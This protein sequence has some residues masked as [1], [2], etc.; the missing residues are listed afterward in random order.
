[1][2]DDAF[3]AWTALLNVVDPESIQTLIH[4]TFSIIKQNWY[5][6][7]TSTQT[8]A[9]EVVKGLIEKHNASIVAHVDMLPSLG[10]I[11]LLQK[12]ESEIQ[13]HKTRLELSVQLQAFAKRCK[14]ENATVVRQALQELE[15]F[16]DKC[17]TVLQESASGHNPMPI[18]G[19]LCRSL[20]DA[21]IRFKEN[22]GEIIDLCAKCLGIIG[23]ID[24]NRVET[25]REKHGILV[26]SNFDSLPEVVEFVAH[27]LE[28]VIV[29]AFRSAPTGKAQSYLAYV[30]QELLKFSGITEAVTKRAKASPPKVA[31]ARWQK[32]PESIQSTLTPYLNSKYR[33][34]NPIIPTDLLGFP[35][36]VDAPAHASWIR[37]LVFTLL[38]RGKGHNAQAIFPVISRVIPGHDLAIATFMLPFVI[39]N[40]VVGGTVD[41]IDFIKKELNSVLIH[42]I[43]NLP[44][45]EAE[46]IKQCSEVSSS[47]AMFD[48]LLIIAECFSSARLPLPLA[49]GEE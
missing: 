16:L 43:E 10:G 7:D 9:S 47:M 33:L 13:A 34:T 27:M 8:R 18:I 37:T 41:E 44:A 15:P 29:D 3:S 21:S 2:V 32:I 49:S 4:H 42:P 6:F 20:L 14:D 1:M 25:V 31:Y 36:D 35:N 28:T 46:N 30:M 12:F 45:S 23:C 38:H 26:L 22:Y 5:T 40:V 19:Q 17:Q 48:Q 11:D 24:S 39:Q